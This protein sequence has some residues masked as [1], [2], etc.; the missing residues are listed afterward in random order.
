MPRQ[1]EAAVV[2]DGLGRPFFRE[3]PVQHAWCVV[4]Q[5]STTTLL[6]MNAHH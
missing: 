6:R 5:S 3:T 2:R 4:R 1:G